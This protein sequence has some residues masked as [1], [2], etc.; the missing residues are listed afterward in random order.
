MNTAQI[1]LAAACYPTRGRASGVWWMLGI[2]RF[3]GIAGSF[4]VA[5]SHPA[6]T[7]ARRHLSRRREARS[8][9]RPAARQ[10]GG[11]SARAEQS[12]RKGLAGA[13]PGEDHDHRLLRSPHNRI[14]RATGKSG[15]Q[16]YRLGARE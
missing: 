8:H 5:E 12:S 7:A 2:G 16:V 6:P 15:A 11:L 1:S 3:G 10:A 9:R 13:L 4:L 14:A